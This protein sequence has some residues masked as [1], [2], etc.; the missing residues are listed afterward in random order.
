MF[1]P[2]SY[3]GITPRISDKAMI[4]PNVIISGDVE[5]GDDT[6][7]W[8][9][10]VIRGDVAPIKIGKQTNIQDGSVI[11][12]TRA[13]HIQ[14]KTNKEIP[15]LIGDYVTIGHKAM[16]HACEVKNYAFIGMNSV[17]LDGVIV[18]EEAMVAAGA[19]ITPGKVVKKRE[20]WAGNPGKFLRKMNDKEI[21]FLEQ[22]S[23]NYVLLAKEY[24]FNDKS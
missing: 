11:H 2:I 7:I 21:A 12:V 23:K 1:K 18:E 22:S 19:V 14:N 9:N 5:I 24:G 17:L 15:T 13:G 4:A 8:Y 6:N 20:I 3:K 10:T 16:L